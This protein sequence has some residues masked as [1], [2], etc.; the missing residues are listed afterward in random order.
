MADRLL[1]EV[2]LFDSPGTPFDP[3]A[4]ESSVG[5]ERDQWGW[6]LIAPD[7]AWRHE[8][9]SM[10]PGAGRRKALERLAASNGWRDGQVVKHQRADGRR[11]YPRASSLSSGVDPAFGLGIWMRRHT[12]LSVARRPDLQELLCSMTYK[13][14]ALIDGVCEEALIRA[15][16][17]DT[18]SE[19]KLMA[20]NRGT[21]F[22]RFT[23]PGSPRV[24][25]TFGP[26]LTDHEVSARGLDKAL[27]ESGLTIVS[28]EQFV[29]SDDTPTAGTYDHLV[30]TE[31][32]TVHVL[33][34][35]TGKKQWISFIVQLEAY[36]AGQH[37]D[38]ITRERT[39]LHEDFDPNLGFIAATDLTTGKCKIFPVKLDGEMLALAMDVWEA[40][41][42]S[43]VKSRVG[44]AL[45]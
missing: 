2:D 17:D 9:R 3:F 19:N 35:K 12:A 29:V 37:Y 26:T 21:T 1:E 10:E 24:D 30:R 45:N 8:A 13:D 44:A 5:I 22:H 42:A 40:N 38:P 7:P 4:R 15:K 20:A 16:D 33:D 25:P 43:V 28:S 31:D 27:V 36:A 39:P 23:T 14:G 18:D 32:G 6:P 11:P 34:K 41:K